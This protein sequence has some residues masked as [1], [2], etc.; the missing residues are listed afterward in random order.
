MTPAADRRE[1]TV[2]IIT[3]CYNGAPYI[4]RTIES[5]LNQTVAPME[6]IVIDDGSTDESASI[7]ES[8]GPPVR[9]IRQAN[10]GESVAR[11]RGIAEARGSHLLFLDADDLLAPESLERLTRA[12]VGRPRSVAIMG[13]A[14]FT[15]DPSVRS[16]VQELRVDGFFPALLEF[17]DWDLWWRV[18]LEAD[19]LVALD[20]AYVGALYRQHAKSQLATTRPADRAFGHAT[21]VGR[22]VTAVLARPDVL[23]Q[24]GERLFWSAWA[25][26]NHLADQGPGAQRVEQL[27]AGLK[28]LAQSGPPQVTR[29]KSAILTRWLGLPNALR[30]RRLLS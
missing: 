20:P 2:S 12:L 18:A 25:A 5:A 8:F 27:E 19:D 14:F 3:P 26:M 4:R 22:M 7:A 24:H 15:D 6:M 1:L 30:L 23:A 16:N 13:Y 9:V 17:E 21:L 10:Q 29:L 11:N 28:T